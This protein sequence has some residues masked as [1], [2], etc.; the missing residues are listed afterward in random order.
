MT[1]ARGETFRAVA[2]PKLLTVTLRVRV[3][4]TEAEAGARIIAVIERFGA[5][6]I[7]TLWEVWA[8]GEE[9]G[10]RPASNPL[11]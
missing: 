1:K 5:V 11:A 2:S 6:W 10:L 9:I 8:S 7:S 4:P 3:C